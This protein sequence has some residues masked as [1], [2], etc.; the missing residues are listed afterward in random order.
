ME[1]RYQSHFCTST[2]TSSETALVALLGNYRSYL[3]DY[4]LYISGVRHA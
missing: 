3:E 4:L 2:S 1:T